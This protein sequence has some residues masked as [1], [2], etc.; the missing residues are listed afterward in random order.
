LVRRLLHGEPS[1]VADAH[2]AVWMNAFEQDG[3]MIVTFLNYQTDLPPVATGP[4]PF[5]L[6][7]TFSSL[8][9]APS[10]EPVPFEVRDGRLH[11][12]LDRLETFSLLV[13][14]R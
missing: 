12:R 9:L 3:R 8:G 14:T 13:A 4:I 10:L 1:F 5:T 6:A 7:G 2:P 11:A